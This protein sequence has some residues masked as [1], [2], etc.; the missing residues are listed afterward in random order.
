MSSQVISALESSPLATSIAKASGENID[1]YVFGL[2]EKSPLQA[3]LY[4]KTTPDSTYTFGNSNMRFSLP[5]FGHVRGSAFVELEITV[6]YDAST[7]LQY[8]YGGINALWKSA[9]LESSSGREI[10]RLLPENV[11]WY[12]S[13][14]PT[15]ERD[16]V[17]ALTHMYPATEIPAPTASDGDPHGL[18]ASSGGKFKGY[19]YLPFAAFQY[20]ETTPDLNFIE[21]LS[22]V[23]EMQ[24]SEAAWLLNNAVSLAVTNPTLLMGFT[25]FGNQQLKAITARNYKVGSVLTIP[26]HEDENLAKKTLDV[27]SESDITG[28]VST[29]IEIDS[30]GLFS[31]FVIVAKYMNNGICKGLCNIESAKLTCA[32]SEIIPEINPN[33]ISLMNHSGY[34]S[35]DSNTTSLND[36]IFCLPFTQSKLRHSLDSGISMRNLPTCTLTL[37][38]KPISVDS[39]DSILVVVNGCRVKSVSYSASSGRANTALNI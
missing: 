24:T 36:E 7:A 35:G 15:A 13:Q 28:T 30:N 12:M 14:L 32:G 33:V 6:K 1:E 38:I 5:R 4:S 25:Q 16:V 26:T 11:M 29:D 3:P 27:S 10:A 17:H 39:G 37:K 22:L 31:K 21:G 18:R 9:R 23:V 8:S 2:A 34:S 20:K 19:I